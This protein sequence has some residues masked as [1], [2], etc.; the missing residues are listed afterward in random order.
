MAESV[1]TERRLGRVAFGAV[2]LVG[3]VAIAFALWHG[4][5]AHR[6]VTSSSA[7]PFSQTAPS[8]F[9]LSSIAPY[10]VASLP[11]GP[12][13]TIACPAGDPQ[14]CERIRRDR[15][16]RT[17]LDT[18]QTMRAQA[19][20]ERVTAAIPGWIAAASSCGADGRCT[21]KVSPP[22]AAQTER[23]LRAAGITD[24]IARQATPQDPAPAGT[25]IVAVQ[26][27]AACVMVTLADNFAFTAE[28]LGPLPDGS[29]FE[30]PT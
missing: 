23:A 5:A 27:A 3:S 11:S 8:V 25:V 18:A 13:A 17:T 30:Q 20:L 10:S 26:T 4:D 29:C 1:H 7:M 24:L 15:R 21:R 2:V 22:T 28:V 9:A 12:A 6:P 19:T 16:S 14:A